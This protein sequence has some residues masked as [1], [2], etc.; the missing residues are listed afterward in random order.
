MRYII[1]LPR[2]NI[3]GLVSLNSPLEYTGINLDLFELTV[4]T[5]SHPELT[6]S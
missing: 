1:S 3:V 5:T 2:S 4:P 6:A